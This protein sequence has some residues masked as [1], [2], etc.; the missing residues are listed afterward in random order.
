MDGVLQVMCHMVCI[1]KV[2]VVCS[3][4][5]RA[6]QAA[7]PKFRYLGPKDALIAHAFSA[8]LQ[9]TVPKFKY[10]GPKDALN[11]IGFGAAAVPARD[12]LL[13][14]PF[15]GQM[16]SVYLFDDA[17]APGQWPA[18]GNKLPGK[19]TDVSVYLFV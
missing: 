17:L 3:H 4:I 8:P 15:Q 9:A 11:A 2:R 19:R 16:G 14:L 1:H 12:G 13:L 18:F 5:L 10:L 6:L 7:V